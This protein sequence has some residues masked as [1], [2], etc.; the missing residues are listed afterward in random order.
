MKNIKENTKKQPFI[1]FD[2]Y[3]KKAD[4]DCYGRICCPE[5]PEIPHHEPEPK[6]EPDY[7]EGPEPEEYEEGSNR[8]Y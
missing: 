7:P 4:E 6:L 5:E 2:E 3:E 1:L 8:E